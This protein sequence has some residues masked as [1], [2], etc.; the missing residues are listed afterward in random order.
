M[1]NAVATTS[2]P[3]ADEFMTKAETAAYLRASEK[4]VE[5]LV[6]RGELVPIRRGIRPFF[7]RVDVAG[8]MAVKG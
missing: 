8:L 1:A 3:V 4:F 5:T 6:K 7:R 2:A